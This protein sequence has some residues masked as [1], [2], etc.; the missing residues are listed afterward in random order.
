LIEAS[1]TAQDFIL[2]AAGITI[3]VVGSAL[4]WFI[5]NLFRD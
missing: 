4:A 2:Y 3:L 5:A 1:Q